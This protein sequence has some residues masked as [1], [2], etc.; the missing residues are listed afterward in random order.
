[1]TQTI[2]PALHYRDADA[3][4][5]FLSAAFGAEEHT[6]YRDDRGVIAH[7]QL[8]IAGSMVMLGQATGDGDPGGETSHPAGAP[9]SLY[10]TVADPDA[11]YATAVAAGATVVR[12]PQDMEYG[13]REYGVRDTEGNGWSFGT[14][15]PFATEHEGDQTVP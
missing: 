8:M 5:A 15:D 1:M 7:A 6:V 13:S 9:I 10:V 4:I 11:H 2:F 12:E 3:A 14:Y